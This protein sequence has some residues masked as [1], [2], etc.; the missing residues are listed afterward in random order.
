MIHLYVNFEVTNLHMKRPPY[1]VSARKID[2]GL[3]VSKFR[4]TYRFR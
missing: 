4:E 2:R 3:Y 1:C